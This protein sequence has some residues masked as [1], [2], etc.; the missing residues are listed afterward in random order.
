M[1]KLKVDGLEIEVPDHYTLLQAAEEAGAEVPRFCFHERLSIAGNCRMCLIEVKG[2]PPKPVASCA[3]GVR[4][5]RPGPNGETPEIFTTTP[6]VKKARE[7]VMEFLLINH[8]L[9]C[10]ICDQGGECDLQDQAM[11]YGVDSSRYQE[12]KRAVEDKYIGPLV[13]TIMTRCIHCTRCVRFTTEVAGISELGLIGRGEDAEIT[14]YLESA[15]TSELQGNVIDLC[16]VGA[17]TSKPYAFQ[18]RPWELTKTESI[19]V[20]DAVG[21]AI[22]VDSRG[23]EVMRIMPR[24]NEQVNEEWISDKTRFIW[25]GLRTQRLD[26]PYVRRNGKLQPASWAEAFAAIKDAVAKTSGDRIGAIAGDLAA[27]EEIYALKALMASLGSANID[28]RQDGA[29]LDPALGRASY[30]FNPTIEGIEQADAILI[31]GANPRF[32]ASVLNA[33]IRKHSRS[34]GALPIAV[35]GDVGDLR[36]DYELLG[37]GP[38]T[39]RE[40]VEGRGSF[41][42]VLKEAARPLIIVG[43][44]ALARPDGAAVLG[45]AAKLAGAVSAVTS[46]WNGFAVL[47]TAAAR[48]GAL[49]VGFVPGEGG[50]DVAGMLGATDVLFLLGADEI[51]MSATGKAFVVYIG[52]HG[53]AGAHRADV[54][55][56]GAAYTEKSGTYVNTEGRVQQTN[57]AGFAPGEAK[58]EWAIFRALS[59]VLGHR[60]PF[61]SLPQLR[62]KLYADYPHLAEV[63]EI[64][65]G[66]PADVANVTRLGG[67]LGKEA[68]VSPV[69][70]F[71]L[72]NPIARASAVMAECS[73]L[74]KGGFKQAAE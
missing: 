19:D 13:K 6:M 26:R 1:A 48:V 68:F 63:D 30:I 27:V 32:E 47:H 31:I 5:L 44:G 42:S 21:S 11:A 57:R 15:M 34:G 28:C 43:Q 45:Q 17:L 8:P 36:Y 40:L 12:N 51:D 72:T 4:D 25:D 18:A 67:V 70:D 46:E 16:P 37:A 69:K 62:A 65:S 58:E 52:T 60:L 53:D 50:K 9:D 23:R 35:I 22:R 64:A 73:A 49:D 7:G 74:A 55:L 33:R 10:P 20:M 59:D 39:L 24:V 14:T 3:M 61:D 29:A 54:I 41:F 38:D 66:N 71:Y 2:G 56:P